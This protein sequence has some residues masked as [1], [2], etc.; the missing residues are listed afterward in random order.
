MC[1]TLTNHAAISR[2][3]DIATRLYS[4][5]DAIVILC[6]FIYSSAFFWLELKPN[7]MAETHGNNNKD[8]Q[9]SLRSC[10]A[11]R[12]YVCNTGLGIEVVN[13]TLMV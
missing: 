13:L 7:E 12:V 4:H 9:T 5:I 6:F 11:V 10:P 3:L 8:N 2:I 1:W